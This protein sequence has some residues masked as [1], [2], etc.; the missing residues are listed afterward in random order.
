MTDWIKASNSVRSKDDAHTCAMV[1]KEYTKS[2]QSTVK[3]IQ[4]SAKRDNDLRNKMKFKQQQKKHDAWIR[5]TVL[6]CGK[7]YEKATKKNLQ[8]NQVYTHK[9]SASLWW[10]QRKRE[11]N[12]MKDEK[13]MCCVKLCYA[14]ELR[15]F[16][17]RFAWQTHK[18]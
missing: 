7:N 13:K 11:S 1:V 12:Q 9:R 10:I 14:S 2:I 3:L 8:R 4:K 6:K 18:L 16:I 17:Y 15:N 5:K